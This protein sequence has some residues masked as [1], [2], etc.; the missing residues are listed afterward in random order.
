MRQTLLRTS[1][2]VGMGSLACAA[3]VTASDGIKLTVG[4]YFSSAYV[5]AF[6]NKKEGRFG[7][8]RNVDAVKHDA[9]VYFS[10]ETTLDNGLTLGARIELEGENDADQIDK[11]YLFWSGG[12]GEVRIGSQNDA[13]ENQCPTPP[14]GTANFSAFSPTGWGANAPISSNSYCFSADNDS[15]KVLYISPVFSGFQLAVSYT[16]S[17]NAEDYTQVGVNGSGTPSSPDGTAHHIVTAYATYSYEGEGWNMTWGGGGSWQGKFNPADGVN[18]GKSQ[19]YQTSGSITIGQIA[20]GGVFQYFSQGGRNN[21]MWIAGGGAAYYAEPMTFGLQYSHGRYKGD[22]LGDGFGTDGA[23]SLNRVVVT[24]IYNLAPGIDLDAD[25]GYTW[26][27]DN[28][29]ATPAKLDD[30]QAFEVGIGSSLS[31]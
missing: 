8:H 22:P 9:E 7:D 21:D 23:L 17:A 13:L 27:H 4:G 29:D 24:A 18:D 31:F 2:L 19:A 12:F 11:S 10:G 15:Q 3:P 5:A 6:D 1:M 25:L 16:P 20:V 28:R 14:G 30:Y 26:Y